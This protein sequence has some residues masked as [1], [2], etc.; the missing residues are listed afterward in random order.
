LSTP[1][2]PDAILETVRGLSPEQRAALQ[3]ALV[4][5]NAPLTHSAHPGSASASND[6]LSRLQSGD[7]YRNGPANIEAQTDVSAQTVDLVRNAQAD[8]V[9][10]GT[11]TATGFVGYD[12]K[13]PASMLIPFMT[14]LLNMTPRQ[15]GV[16]IDVHHWKAV[17]DFFG[18]SGPQSVIGSVS[19]GGTPSFVSRSVTSMQNNFQTI[20]LQDS[21]T[22]QA[23]WRARSFEGDLRAL[24][25]AQLLYALKLVEE[26]WLI[27]MSDN[28]WTP[29]PPLVVTAITGGSLASTN[30]YW[31]A[32]TSVNA[33]GETLSTGILGP[34]TIAS[35]SSGSIA[36]TLFTVPNATKYNV[37]AATAASKPASSA[38]YLQ[39]ASSNFGGASALNQPSSPI[40]GNFAATMTTLTSSGTA[41]S[42]VTSNTAVVSPDGS[43][44]P[45]T[46]RGVLGLIYNN[47]GSLSTVGA[48][49]LVTNVVQ[50]AATTGYLALSDIQTLFLN[51]FNNARANPEYLYVS[52]QDSITI[53]NLVSANSNTRIVV[54]ADNAASQNNLI[55]GYR[56]GKILNEVTQRLVEI[57]PLPYLP[58]GT[59]I[60][61]SMTFP[62]PVAGYTDPPFRVIMNQD[63]YGV[64]YE[65]T[66][67]TPT[68]YGYGVF[69]DSTVVMEFL[70]GWGS[71]QGIVYH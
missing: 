31:F 42:S 49:G 15:M 41:L 3:T 23:T 61:G 71:I 35:G 68:K 44:N 14:P 6:A 19:D 21:F 70:G 30:P 13:A 10:T 5:A 29:P 8:F 48:G 38:M 66:P 53:S 36:L 65:P 20:G 27:T 59:I 57:V 33:T 4:E 43:N 2:K 22:F 25:S 24:L 28:L 55:A 11:T 63:Y 9:R 37:Y 51:M 62:Y 52:P 54:N 56:V 50:P 60:A 16:G 67:A 40:A 18:G 26:N 1:K 39:S 46:W 58:Q 69:V 32:V 12:L 7:I 64:D 47:T 45:T 34:Y 17:T